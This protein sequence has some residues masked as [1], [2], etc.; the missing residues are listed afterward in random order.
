MKT[1]HR[2]GPGRAL[3]RQHRRVGVALSLFFIVICLTGVL[4]NHSD[5]LALNQKTV[6]ADW[7]YDWYGIAPTGSPTHYQLA[8]HSL[9]HLSGL[10]YLDGNSVGEM[11]SLIGAVELENALLAAAPNALLLVSA[12]GDIIERMTGAALPARPIE[13]ICESGGRVLIKTPA[14][15]FRSDAALLEWEPALWTSEYTAAQPTP[16]PAELE[17]TIR[18]SYR[19]EGISWDRVLL[20][21]H[22]GRFFGPVG[23]WIAD[24]S[25]LG[26]VFLTLSGLFYTSKYLKKARARSIAETE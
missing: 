20:D 10:L 14:G 21:L 4:L 6:Q 9:A 13:A 11:D 19:G 2:K 25:A 8:N 17:K 24:L 22:S 23:K 26:L 7:I 1:R 3:L 5:D 15:A 12:E 16:P 18:A